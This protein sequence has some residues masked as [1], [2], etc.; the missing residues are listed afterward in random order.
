MNRRI[1]QWVA[2]VMVIGALCACAT[3]GRKFDRTHVGDVKTGVQNKDQIR[4]WFGKPVSMQTLASH[5][6]GCTERWTYVHAYASW[7]GAKSTAAA[8]IVDFDKAGMVCDHAYSE[9]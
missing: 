2:A 7:G 1:M 6:A 9:Q 8:L 3:S 4:A 5:P